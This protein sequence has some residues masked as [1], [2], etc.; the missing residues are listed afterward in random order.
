MGP[1]FVERHPDKRPSGNR[2]EIEDRDK[3]KQTLLVMEVRGLGVIVMRASQNPE[4][5]KYEDDGMSI[6]SRDEILFE[7]GEFSLEGWPNR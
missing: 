1:E 4:T 2:Y 6:F 3:G 5:G 7:D